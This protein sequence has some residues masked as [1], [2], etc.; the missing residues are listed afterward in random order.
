[1]MFI[2]TI[3]EK[4]QVKGANTAKEGKEMRRDSSQKTNKNTNKINAHCL[5]SHTHRKK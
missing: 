2:V 1:M 3:L 4:V 5:F